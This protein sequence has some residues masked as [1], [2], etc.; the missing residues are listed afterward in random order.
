MQVTLNGRAQELPEELTLLELLRRL[1]LGNERVAVERN[2]E[3]VKRDDWPAVRVQPGDVL[4]IVH[5][6]GGG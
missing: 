2:R 1:E 5:F 3:I 4:E 6:V